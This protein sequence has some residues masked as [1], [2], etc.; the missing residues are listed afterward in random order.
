MK[1][2]NQE[3]PTLSLMDELEATYQIKDEFF[4][5]V[6][7]KGEILKFRHI[8]TITD[9]KAL[10]AKQEEFISLVTGEKVHPTWKKYLPVDADVARTLATI[11]FQSVEPKLSD[12]DVLRLHSLPVIAD[13]ISSQILEAKLL[14]FDWADA[15]EVEDE[16]KD[17]NP[18]DSEESG[19]KSVETPSTSTPTN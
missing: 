5:V 19:S 1:K 14:A 18:T 10:R 15:Q 4:E 8:L 3:S 9:R 2:S 7:P 11:A 16:K 6:L 13:T 17:S 12:F